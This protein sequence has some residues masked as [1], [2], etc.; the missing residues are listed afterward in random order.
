MSR[1]KVWYNVSIARLS[2]AK[3][4]AGQIKIY[5]IRVL[6]GYCTTL[7]AHVKAGSF[8]F[9]RYAFLP[10]RTGSISSAKAELI[11]PG[12]ILPGTQDI[13]MRDFAST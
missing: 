2:E 9:I 10:D 11:R 1:R 4:W 3:N 7:S 8:L 13:R 5:N 12:E 6:C